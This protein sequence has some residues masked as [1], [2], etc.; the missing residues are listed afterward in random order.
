MK[1][2]AVLAAGLLDH[3]GVLGLMER[4]D[5]R[6]NLLRV[7]TYHRVDDPA[8]QPDLDP[9]LISATPPEFAAQ[10]ALLRRHYA[11]VSLAQ[12]RAAQRGGK[13]L[14]PRAVLVTF[15]DA[16]RDF[17]EHAWPI[18]QA[19]DVPVTLFVPTAFPDAGDTGFWWDRLRCALFRSD[20]S[21]LTLTDAARTVL[22]LAHPA[23]RQRAWK[24]LRRQI[25]SLPHGEAMDA[26]AQYLDV[27]GRPPGLHHV[28]DWESLRRL[29]A[30]GVTVCPHGHRH[31][32]MTRLDAA[33]LRQDLMESRAHLKDALG[34]LATLDAMAYPANST[35]PAVR[36][37]VAAA[38]FDLAFAGQRG[39]NRM[40]S[41][42]PLAFLRLPAMRHGRGLFRAQLRPAVSALSR[43]LTQGRRV[44]GYA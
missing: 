42:D 35:S 41:A 12:V 15:D 3:S 24:V 23:E 5:R 1:R 11:P 44:A 30:Q 33:Q 39:V 18:L 36:E 25:K 22:P 38:G 9:G 29:A 28:L 26:V 8:A 19:H 31:A 7:L 4:C 32:L 21:A 43:R 27:L 14:P 37:A 16:Y 40:P 13:A 34:E 20:A 17:A 2:A 6:A 10:M